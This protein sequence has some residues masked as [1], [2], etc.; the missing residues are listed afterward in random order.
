[1]PDPVSV[2]EQARSGIQNVLHLP[3]SGLAVIP[4]T[5]PGR[6]DGKENF[7]T[8]YVTITLNSFFHTTTLERSVGVIC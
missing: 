4:D 6:N 3:D 1:M 2:T 8:F 7:S 5:D